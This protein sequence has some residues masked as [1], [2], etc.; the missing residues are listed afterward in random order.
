MNNVGFTKAENR[1]KFVRN[2]DKV[3][4]KCETRKEARIQK[5]MQ[6]GVCPRCRDKAKWRFQYDKYKPLKQPAKCKSCHQKTVVKAYHTF[7]NPC[8]K[9]KDACP[10]C[11]LARGEWREELKSEEYDEVV[12]DKCEV[13][14]EGDRGDVAGG[15]V[16]AVM[17]EE[18]GEEV[19]REQEDEEPKE[20]GGDILG[21]DEKAFMS[22]ATSK[23]SKARDTGSE[24][25]VFTFGNP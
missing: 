2:R 11:C 24:A 9:Q 7:C 15:G 10:G 3:L 1:K 19:P 16:G 17:M 8:A 23:Y 21:W 12:Y 22:V 13:E 14:D 6:E 20:E 18:E 4:K 5:G 25:D